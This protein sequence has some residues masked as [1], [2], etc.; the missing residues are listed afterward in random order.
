[1][2]MEADKDFNLAQ[3]IEKSFK[4]KSASIDLMIT[5]DYLYYI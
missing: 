5:I 2:P 4:N 3:E 1:M